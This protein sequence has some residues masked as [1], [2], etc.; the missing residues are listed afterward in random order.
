MVEMLL[1][2]DGKGRILI[3]R[4]LR[5]KLGIGRL[6]RAR[7]EEG[8]I[9]IEPVGDPLELLEKAVVKGTEDVE[10]EIGEL[11]RVAEAELRKLVEG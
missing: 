2:V 8:R 7:V 6:V 11:R 3:P 9:V 4:A 1:R 10:R 5:E